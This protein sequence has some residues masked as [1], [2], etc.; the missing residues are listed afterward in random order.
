MAA[1]PIQQDDPAASPQRMTPVRVMVVDDSVVVRSLLQRWLTGD[2]RID[3]VGMA[4]D[5]GVALDLLKKHDV[6]VVVLDIAM[7]V[8]DG[9]TAL[10]RMRV[11]QPHAQ[12]IISS[13]LTTQNAEI[14]LAALHAGAAD[15]VTKPAGK[16]VV[17]GGQDFFTHLLEKILALGQ[18]AQ[19]KK[20]GTEKISAVPSDKPVQAAASG[21][22][23]ERRTSTPSSPALT[24]KQEKNGFTPA[25]LA[26][27]ASTGG[28]QALFHL[29]AELPKPFALPIVIVQ[30]MPPLFT[31]I[32]AQQ[33]T[34][35]TG[36]DTCEAKDAQL[37]EAGKAYIAP[38]DM[39]MRIIRDGMRACIA[40]SQDAPVNYCRPAVD[41]FFQSLAE[42]YGSHVL[43]VVLTGMGRDG[44]AGARTLA[45]H[46]SVVLAQDEAT[47]VVWGMPGMIA[48]A[49]LASDILP[50]AKIA[51]AISLRLGGKRP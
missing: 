4:N 38:G 12:I 5:G 19:N 34:R 36:V 11:L 10:P 31:D 13:T 7:P 18:V 46:G 35:S 22:Q 23:T 30:H 48:K 16:T 14:S 26:I 47:S 25:I 1:V 39:H 42:S 24:L 21:R 37:L 15:Y 33:L 27:G 44:L 28:P 3:L 49:G 29:L 43:A 51:N 40:L 50:L 2:D 45:D 9:M 17:L 41:P 32:L 20:S 6:D 8:M